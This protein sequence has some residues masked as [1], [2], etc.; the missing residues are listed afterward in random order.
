VYVESKMAKKQM[1][2]FEAFK[3]VKPGD[4][5]PAAAA[6]T[7]APRAPRK[8]AAAQA[9]AAKP[10]RA[11]APPTP[12]AVARTLLTPASPEGAKR[13]WRSYISGSAV[14]LPREIIAA[15]AVAALMMF[16]LVGV[17]SYHVGSSHGRN[18]AQVAQAAGSDLGA[19][20]MAIS[21]GQT[22]EPATPDAD[23][24]FAPFYSLCIVSGMTAKDAE[25]IRAD[26]T[27][28]QYNAFV[29]QYNGVYAVYVGNFK[30]DK[31][32]ALLKLQEQF[33]IMTYQGRQ[34]FKSCGVV[35]FQ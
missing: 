28:K 31:D 34:P 25:K 24:G 11:A 8:M 17:I 10:P 16:A 15:A 14:L 21:Y 20:P 22:Q 5:K 7:I 26:M 29:R 33:R 27:A 19:M 13:S 2:F 35:K 23:K 4:V 1:A 9:P 6:K 18:S 3:V 30:S 12:P 32:A